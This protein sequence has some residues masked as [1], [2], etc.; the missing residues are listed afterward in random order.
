MEMDK[1]FG[2]LAEHTAA[3]WGMVTAQQA[4]A[5]GVDAVTLYRLKEAGFLD[6]ARRG[7]YVVTSIETHR[8]QA[9]QAA[10]LALRP[11]VPAWEREPLDSNDGVLSHGTAARLHGFGELV[12]DGIV[13][14]VPRRRTTRHP[15]LR[16]AINPRLDADDV[17]LVDGL[18]VT[19]MLRTVD[20]LLDSHVDGSH[21]A[22]I[23]RE[24]VEA[25][26]LRLDELAERITPYAR[27]YR[28]RPTTGE[29]LLEHL[30]EQIGL[31]TDE[32]AARPRPGQRRY[33]LGDAV[34]GTSILD[35]INN[36]LGTQIKPIL[37][38]LNESTD[39]SR[40]NLAR[41]FTAAQQPQIAKLY[42]QL[43]DALRNPLSASALAQVA[44][45]LPPASGLSQAGTAI[46]SAAPAA[47]GRLRLE[48]NRDDEK[49]DEP[50]SADD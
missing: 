41:E 13:F 44:A 1:A 4:K 31:T 26:A 20:D 46:A 39:Q 18:P 45:T 22:T 27:R 14:T 49:R 17:T 48:Q 3:Q 36:A 5:L 15:D 50:G 29:A 10:W 8:N 40:I 43:A 12:D 6:V 25:G 9:E 30:L 32:L 33:N 16:F 38:A 7:V 37:A 2:L 19:T 35:A 21:V 28:V 42:E 23:I 47:T 11:A 24:A 34:A